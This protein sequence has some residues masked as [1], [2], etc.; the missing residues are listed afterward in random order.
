VTGGAP[1]ENGI[2]ERS[3]VSERSREICVEADL[4]SEPRVRVRPRW[5][6]W[7]E[8]PR[9]RVAGAAREGALERLT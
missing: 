2:D 8:A 9:E 6:R 7:R 4:G 1:V 5:R 3:G